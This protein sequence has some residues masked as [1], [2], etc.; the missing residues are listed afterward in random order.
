MSIDVS[1]PLGGYE[2]HGASSW[3]ALSSIVGLTA[4]VS[5]P[6]GGCN[7]RVGKRDCAAIAK[8]FPETVQ[9]G[10]LAYRVYLRRDPGAG[11]HYFRFLDLY[12][13]D[14]KGGHMQAVSVDLPWDYRLGGS[15]RAHD[16]RMAMGL[17][18]LVGQS[19]GAIPADRVW[20]VNP[21]LR[22]VMPARRLPVTLTRLR[23]LKGNDRRRELR[24][25]RNTY[26][27]QEQARGI[28]KPDLAIL[29]HRDEPP[30][31]V[32]SRLLLHTSHIPHYWRGVLGFVELC[33]K[34]GAGG[35]CVC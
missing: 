7:A 5:L 19:A 11:D 3:L 15:A 32:L 10:R 18:G 20:I 4:R 14:P 34:Y 16:R 2:R 33:R 29:L 31:D 30:R 23:H 21:G 35:M 22:T 24:R 9:S 12:V 28:M 27:D 1:F 13:E 25:G 26:T 6:P 8:R 17:A